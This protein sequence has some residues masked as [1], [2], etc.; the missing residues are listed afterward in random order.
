MERF[1]VV[2]FV[3]QN[4]FE[5]IRMSLCSWSA[6]SW[7]RYVDRFYIYNNRDGVFSE[8]QTRQLM[9]IGLPLEIRLTTRGLLN[10]NNGKG[11]EAVLNQK[12]A[13]IEVCKEYERGWMMKMDS[14]ILVKDLRLLEHVEFLIESEGLTPE[15]IYGMGTLNNVDKPHG[16]NMQGGVY[17]LSIERIN[18]GLLDSFDEMDPVFFIKDLHH[19]EDHMFTFKIMQKGGAIRYIPGYFLDRLD[20]RASFL[21]FRA[22]SKMRMPEVYEQILTDKNLL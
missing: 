11:R 16:P 2:Y 10:T 8:E 22:R 4:H 18:G 20:E 5:L 7:N 17:F 3:D 19:S 15:N 12:E 1:P 14:D 21:H 6:T 9:D 13:Y